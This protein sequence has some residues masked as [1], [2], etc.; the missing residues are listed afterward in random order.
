MRRGGDDPI[1]NPTTHVG[2]SLLIQEIYDAMENM[3]QLLSSLSSSS[4]RME[5]SVGLESNRKLHGMINTNN[6][7][8]SR[9]LVVTGDRGFCA[10]SYIPHFTA[11]HIYIH[12][13]RRLRFLAD[14]DLGLSQLKRRVE[15]G[16]SIWINNSLEITSAKCLKKN[17]FLQSP[18]ASKRRGSGPFRGTN[19][20]TVPEPSTIADELCTTLLTPYLDILLRHCR[21]PVQHQ[22]LTLIVN[23]ALESMLES[24]LKRKLRFNE[25]GVGL[26]HAQLDTLLKWIAAAKQQLKIPP[27]C[28]LIQDTKPWTRVNALLQILLSACNGALPD[29]NAPV[30]KPLGGGL[31]TSKDG[32]GGGSRPVSRSGMASRDRA[33]SNNHS[34]FSSALGESSSSAAVVASISKKERDEWAALAVMGSLKRMRGKRPVFVALKLNLAQL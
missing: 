18:G 5:L 17:T 13:A 27:A 10:Q 28:P 33:V 23:G 6:F 29:A 31:Y 34:R 30:N 3:Q 4:V 12:L 21:P 14:D 19:K 7:E 2:A 9:R 8:Q 1:A 15:A 25:P 16:L 20:G 32:P 11:I 22:L 24:I 26:L